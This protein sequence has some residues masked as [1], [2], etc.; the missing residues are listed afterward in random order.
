MT[1]TA[2]YTLEQFNIFLDGRM[3]EGDRQGMQEHLAVC[4][5]CRSALDNLT[6]IDAALRGL[7]VA[8]VRPDFTR[9]VMDRILATQRP[10]FV[11]RML[12]K[13]PYVFGLLVVLGVMVASF[14]LTGVFDGSQLDQGG[15]VATGLAGKAGEVLTGVTGMFTVWLVRYLPFAFGKDSMGVAVF[16]VAVI[17]MLAAV[18]RAVAKK[19][20]QR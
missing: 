16:A 6:R 12:E 15:S 13:L 4:T 9:S 14:V 17:V 20:M 19:V 18:D 8:Q 2:H 5:R 3:A 1:A 10:S 7:P 11:F